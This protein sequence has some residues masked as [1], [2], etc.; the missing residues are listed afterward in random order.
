MNIQSHQ[1]MILGNFGCPRMSLLHQI[2]H[3]ITA[4]FSPYCVLS[5]EITLYHVC[6]KRPRNQDQWTHVC[7]LRCCINLGWLF[8]WQWAEMTQLHNE[9]MQTSSVHSCIIPE[10]D[11]GY[12][13]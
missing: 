2:L 3:F 6:K 4:E 10:G 8:Y 1:W 11:G 9:L 13:D 12:T 7:N 5:K